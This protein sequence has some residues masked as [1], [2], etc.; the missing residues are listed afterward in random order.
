MRF[1]KLPQDVELA[2]QVA[3]ESNR[4]DL[5]ICSRLLVQVLSHIYE[6]VDYNKYSRT[7]DNGAPQKT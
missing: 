6:K 3:K 4:E 7:K 1:R 2:K 5:Y